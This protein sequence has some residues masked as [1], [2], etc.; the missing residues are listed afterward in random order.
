MITG[1]RVM[2]VGINVLLLIEPDG[3]PASHHMSE[4]G[5]DHLSLI[6]SQISLTL[7]GPQ[8]ASNEDDSLIM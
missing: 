5:K 3:K 1:D 2:D 8:S 6:H 7:S 4:R